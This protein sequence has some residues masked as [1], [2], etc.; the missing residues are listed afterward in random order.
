MAFMKAWVLWTEERFGM[1]FF[2]SHDEGERIVVSAVSRMD[3]L[4]FT[5][6]ASYVEEGLAAEGVIFVESTAVD[7][8]QIVIFAFVPGNL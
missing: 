4:N 7:I 6:V 5:I 8:C 2:A 1:D 3:T